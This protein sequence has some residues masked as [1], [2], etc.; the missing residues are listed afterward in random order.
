[1]RFPMSYRLLSS[2]MM[3][4]ALL[5]QAATTEGGSDFHVRANHHVDY[6]SNK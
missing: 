4:C 3:I 6:S 2:A 1:M 5:Y